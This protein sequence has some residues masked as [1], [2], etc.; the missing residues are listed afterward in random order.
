MFTFIS[1]IVGW[2][3]FPWGPIY[4]V[5]SIFVNLG[6]GKDVTDEVIQAMQAGENE[7]AE[8]ST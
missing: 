4:T 7:I 3:G 5:Q 8:E 6:D 1:R 2:W